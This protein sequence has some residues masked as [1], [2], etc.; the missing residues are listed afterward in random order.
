MF[1][2]ALNLTLPL[3]PFP[4]A[5]HPLKEDHLQEIIL[6]RMKTITVVKITDN[7]L[8]TDHLLNLSLNLVHLH[9]EVNPIMLHIRLNLN[10][11]NLNSHHTLSLLNHTQD[12]DHMLPIPPDHR[13]QAMIV[14]IDHHHPTD[15]H[16]HLILDQLDPTLA[17]LAHHLHPPH[18]PTH[19]QLHHQITHPTNQ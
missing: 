5:A 10:H 11:P 19:H 3:N 1:P 4:L 14:M 18:H 12:Q 15:Q 16:H 2:V 6:A 7:Q 9:H 13:I 17:T 8:L